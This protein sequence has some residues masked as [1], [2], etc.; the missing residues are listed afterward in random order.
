MRQLSYVI[1][2]VAAG[3]GFALMTAAGCFPFLDETSVGGGGG[4]T[5]SSTGGT[6]CTSALACDDGNACTAETCTDGSCVYIPLDVAMEP[7]SNECITIACVKGAPTTTIHDGIACGFDGKL[8]CVG[9]VCTGCQG[10]AQCGETDECQ[11]STC[12]PNMTCKYDYTLAGTKVINAMPADIAGDCMATTCDG[13]GKSKPTPD[14]LDVPADEVCTAGQCLNGA[15]VQ[16]PLALGTKCADGATFCNASQTC[17]TCTI[18]AGCAMGT[19]CYQETGCVSCGDGFKNGDETAVDCGGSC[20][21]CDDKLACVLDKDCKNMRCVKKKCISCSDGV[22]NADEVETDCGGTSCLACLGTPC[23]VA[24]QCALGF[25]SDTFCC[26]SACTAPCKSCNAGMAG[27]CSDAS[28]GFADPACPVATPV[29][30]MTGGCV[31]DM[32]KKHLGD[33]CSIN[34]DCFSN[35]CQGMTGMKTCQ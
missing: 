16:T 24:G 8:L 2:V 19:T 33:M 26:N 32:G 4:G 35:N 1:A 13:S 10:D 28:F 30:N 21:P 29:C 5:S 14:A 31:D 15:P 20:S 12:Q 34:L 25:C 11:K 9:K 3:L 6:P 7:G 17:V 18:N 27:T 22:K 23:S